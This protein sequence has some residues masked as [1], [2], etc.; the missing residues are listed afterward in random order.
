ML[1]CREKLSKQDFYRDLEE[2][3]N[4]SLDSSNLNSNRISS[5]SR[6]ISSEFAATF[7]KLLYG[8]EQ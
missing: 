8:F 7:A 3:A 1:I 5:H 4:G 6:S 2:T